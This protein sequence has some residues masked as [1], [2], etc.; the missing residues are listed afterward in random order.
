MNVRVTEH[1]SA[2]GRVYCVVHAPCA[3]CGEEAEGRVAASRKDPDAT[4]QT[5]HTWAEAVGRGQCVLWCKSCSAARP[6]WAAPVARSGVVQE[7]APPGAAGP[8]VPGA[9]AADAHK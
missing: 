2:N 8:T 5:A 6:S 1:P 4:R 9:G 7:D 3:S